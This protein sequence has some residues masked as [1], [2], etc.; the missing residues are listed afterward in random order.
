MYI[1]P[2]CRLE[3]SRFNPQAEELLKRSFWLSAR[4][5]LVCHH[6]FANDKRQVLNVY[7]SSGRVIPRLSLSPYG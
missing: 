7:R 4:I 2:R 1:A 3:S 6:S 5:V